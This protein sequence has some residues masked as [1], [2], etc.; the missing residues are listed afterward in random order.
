M[1]TSKK[2]QFII[3]IFFILMF[4]FINSI[5][6]LLTFQRHRIFYFILLISSLYL[7]QNKYV[8][9]PFLGETVI[10]KSVIVESR[11]P[12]GADKEYSLKLGQ[13]IKDGVKV[14]YWASEKD[15]NKIISNPW[16]AYG[17]YMNTGVSQVKDGIAILKYVDPTKYEVNGTVL[18]K[19][20][21]YRLCCKDNVMLGEVK[22]IDLENQEQ[23]I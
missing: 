7:L 8:F 11:T 23:I 16:D 19:H 20:L 10:P 17:K 18:P 15:E 6:N 5:Y 21:H 14:I 22:T 2:S 9:L 4:C 1:D 12:D 3:I 13:N